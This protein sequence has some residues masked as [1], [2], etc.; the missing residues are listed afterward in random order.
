MGF[1]VIG[2]G[3]ALIIGI[4]YAII[5]LASNVV[6]GLDKIINKN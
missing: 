1:I 3:L 5:N 4:Y 6:N 2:L